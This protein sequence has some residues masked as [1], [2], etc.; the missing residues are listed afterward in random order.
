MDSGKCGCRGLDAFSSVV[1]DVVSSYETDASEFTAE[2]LR[3]D[4]G[5][6][7]YYNSNIVMSMDIISQIPN[8]DWAFIMFYPET[9]YSNLDVARRVLLPYSS[10]CFE[11]GLS[12]EA[13]A[14]GRT[15][16]QTG[17]KSLD[18]KPGL[19]L[20]KVALNTLLECPDFIH[21]GLGD[22]TQ[23]MHI[24][25]QCGVYVLHTFRMR[26]HLGTIATPR[27]LPDAAMSSTLMSV[28]VDDYDRLSALREE[29]DERR[30]FWETLYED[31]DYVRGKDAE[32]TAVNKSSDI[33]GGLRD[34]VP[35]SDTTYPTL[36]LQNLQQWR[37]FIHGKDK[38]IP[39]AQSGVAGYREFR[40][41]TFAFR[42]EHFVDDEVRG[43]ST[44]LIAMK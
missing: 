28:W 31:L 44:V 38:H 19:F 39:I 30:W 35:S 3:T 1:I 12:D 29:R 8:H 33:A 37:R 43:G 18:L 17:M 15:I 36:S 16:G 14:V 6:Q 11:R 27:G 13:I 10:D 40:K 41:T 26:S 24:L 22:G 9:T 23:A 4:E 34:D 20:N 5:E 7:I 2:G 32:L 42:G 25:T 21:N